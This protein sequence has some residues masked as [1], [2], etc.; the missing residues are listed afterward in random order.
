[1][2]SRRFDVPNRP[3]ASPQYYEVA[4]E[5][6]RHAK[7]VHLASQAF[8]VVLVALAIYLAARSMARFLLANDQAEQACKAK[9]SQPCHYDGKEWRP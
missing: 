3:P 1:M 5:R 6:E 9:Y 8:A 4:A 2:V 7:L